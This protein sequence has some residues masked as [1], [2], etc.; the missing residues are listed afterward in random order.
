M[1]DKQITNK[2]TEFSKTLR[3]AFPFTIPVLTGF[4]VL[5]LAYGVLM[6]TKGYGPL[7]AGLISAIAF[8]GSMQFVA[9]TLLTTA[10]DPLQAF[11]LSIMV[12]ARHIFYG[13]SLLEKYK[14]LGWRRFFCIYTLCDENFSVA[15]SIEPPNHVSQGN[16]YFVVS[17]LNWSYWVIGSILG[18]IAGNFITFNTKGLDFALTA[19][20]VVLLI[21][22]L[23][24]KENRIPAVIG[25]TATIAS[26][27]IFKAENLVIPAMVLILVTLVIGRKKIC[28]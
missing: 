5:G 4:L 9:I 28:P 24:K 11:L 3:A 14:G 15:S 22:Q 25:I 6:N 26:L 18:G 8:C 17:M 12:N 21:E 2:H 1:K 20:F 13:L 10:F 19:L 16:F 23:S 27:L 7:W